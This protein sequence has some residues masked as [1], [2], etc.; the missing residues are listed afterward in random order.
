MA[1]DIYL[2]IDTDPN[3]DPTQIEVQDPYQQFMQLIEMI[4][5]TNKGE[6]LG[7]C[8]LGANLDSYLW[9]TS[10]SSNSIKQE[11]LRQIEMFGVQ[12][13]NQIK[14]DVDVN[15]VQG[16]ISDTIIVDIYIEDQKVYGVAV[17]P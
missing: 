11:I 5:T 1:I 17:T 12:F 15:F 16:D 13:T 6:V 4:L 10:I 2:R 8:E 7:S 14:Y 9:N 3:Y